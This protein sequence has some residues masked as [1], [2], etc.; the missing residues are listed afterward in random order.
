MKYSV[1][2]ASLL[3]VVTVQ[4]HAQDDPEPATV[5]TFEVFEDLFGKEEPLYLTLRT[6]VRQFTR[7]KTKKKYQPARMICQV[8]DTFRVSTPV[9]IKT[10]GIF[11]LEWCTMPPIWLNIRRSGIKVEELKDIKRMKM[12][13]RCRESAPYKNYVLREYLVYRIYS[14]ITPYSYRTRLVR[15]RFE[16]TGKR[17]NHSEDWAFLIEPEDMMAQ[18]LEGRFFDN[19]KLS[20]KTV[21][22]GMIDLVAMFQYMVGNGDYSVTGRHNLKI[23]AVNPPGPA[24]FI[25][26]PYDFDYTGLVNTNYST[27]QENLGIKSVRE[28]Y[29]LGPC[30]TD[31]QYIQAIR[32]L[33]EHKEEIFELILGFEYLDE[34]ERHKMVSYLERFYDMAG[35]KRFIPNHI[36]PTCQ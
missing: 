7:T 18:R 4:V 11:R 35:D 10:R 12:V 29:F 20:I 16:D 36:A 22:P 8:N 5:D 27:P 13:I 33:E 32:K 28:R 21:N 24:G 19:D 14:L 26:V 31:A 25:P 9:R 3:L 1:L 2:L 23:L 15:L 17:P 34:N 6:D 30:R